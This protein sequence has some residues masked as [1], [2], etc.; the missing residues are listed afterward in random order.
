LTARVPQDQAAKVLAL[1]DTHK[2]I[3]V[4]DRATS[5]GVKVSAPA[6]AEA[7]AV[8]ALPL[9][10]R[11]TVAATAEPTVA[12]TKDEIIRLAEEQLNVGK[13]QVQTGITR[14]RRFVTER[15]VE[16]NVTLHEEHAEVLRRAVNDPTFLTDVDWSDKTVDVTETA[17]QAVVGKT[18]RVIEEVAVR[19]DGSDRVET[20]HDTVRRQNIEVEKL[21]ADR[22]AT[23]TKK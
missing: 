10:A 16:A 7:A 5:L 14:V 19:K 20:V 15:E 3:D 9:P 1:L 4:V 21:P 6:V 23:T 12:R 22:T 8:A 11:T 2:P 13:T 17:E 18:S